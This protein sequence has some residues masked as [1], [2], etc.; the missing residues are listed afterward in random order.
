MEDDT[1]K[2]VVA[3]IGLSIPLLLASLFF[4]N[5]VGL[6][7]SSGGA[8]IGIAVVLLLV[9]IAFFKRKEHWVVASVFWGLLLAI[10]IGVV[11]FSYI[12][13]VQPELEKIELDSQKTKM[14]VIGA[15]SQEVI[16]IL[17]GNR[18]II[19]YDL[20][21]TQTLERNPREIIAKYDI[22]MLDQSEEAN[23]E[24]SKKFGEAI[25]IFVNNGGKF[26]LVK[27]SGTRRPDTVDVI[28]WRNTFGDIIP[29]EC[30]RNVKDQPTCTN[31]RIIQ[32]KILR[33]DEDHPI[34]E[35]IET[36][37]SD[38]LRNATFESFK[39]ALSGKE[40]AFIQSSSI[41]SSIFVGIAEKPLVVGKSIY[42]NYNP[43]KTRGIFESTLDYLRHN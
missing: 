33:Q 31:R 8:I 16:D 29:V 3:S 34:M 27:D 35:G 2:I 5:F 36:F 40:I 23:K 11:V 14:L 20:K 4:A 25:Q 17:N 22:V 9:I 1:I 32:G 38:P 39:V 37:P 43:G 15:S 12:F 7:F 24:V 13:V 19:D 28:G 41:D 10:I 18:D 42:F 26:I 21:T 6:I 30:N